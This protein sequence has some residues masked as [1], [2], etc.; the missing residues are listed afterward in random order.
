MD[1]FKF[2]LIFL[3]LLSCKPQ[4]EVV[5]THIV[6]DTLITH[7]VENVT[8]PTKN[9]TIL[10]TPCKN[11]SLTISDQTIKTGHTTLKIK[12]SQ[13]S[14]IIEQSTDTIKETSTVKTKKHSEKQ[15][16]TI[17]ITKTVVPKWA[18]WLL[19]ITSLYVAYR[20]LR[21]QFPFLRILPI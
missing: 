3:L 9:I 21:F 18:W 16:E 11:D 14:L 12:E 19:G 2:V 8:L 4:Q 17:T 5:K 10:D 13:G 15:V 1:N 20:I 6:S 7:H